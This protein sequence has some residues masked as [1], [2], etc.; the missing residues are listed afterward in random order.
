MQVHFKT[1]NEYVI[2]ECKHVGMLGRLHDPAG[3]WSRM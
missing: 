2:V 3:R 1:D